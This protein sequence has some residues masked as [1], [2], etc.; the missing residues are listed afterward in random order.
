MRQASNEWDETTLRRYFHTWDVD[1]ILRIK[2]PTNKKP[3]WVAWQ[4]EK[5]RVFSVKS[6]R[7]D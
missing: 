6:T 7:P 4:Y 5:S 1:E 2:L 3:D